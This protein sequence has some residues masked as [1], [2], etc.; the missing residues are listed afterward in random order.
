MQKCHFSKEHFFLNIYES[1]LLWSSH[2]V[3]IGSKL[4]SSL[5]TNSPVQ[6]SSAALDSKLYK[7]SAY[8]LIYF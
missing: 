7:R 3:S 6:D 1:N 4:R 5:S 8:F 2:P